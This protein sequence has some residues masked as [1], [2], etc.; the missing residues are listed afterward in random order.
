MVAAEADTATQADI[1]RIIKSMDLRDQKILNLEANLKQ[2]HADYQKLKEDI[3]RLKPLPHPGS[4]SPEHMI[5][6]DEK[7]PYGPITQI[8]ETKGL[9]REFPAR[10]FSWATARRRMG[11]QSMFFPGPLMKEEPWLIL[12]TLI[13]YSPHDHKPLAR[14]TD[15]VA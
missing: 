15:T 5:D 4:Q 3:N 8:A 12:Q 14:P 1:S 13:F 7:S 6:S 2:L 10:P 9:S 11:L